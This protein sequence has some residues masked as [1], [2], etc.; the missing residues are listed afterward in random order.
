MAERSPGYDR[1]QPHRR[2]RAHRPSMMR[3]RW[4]RPQPGPTGCTTTADQLDAT[5]VPAGEA[6]PGPPRPPGHADHPTTRQRPRRTPP[7]PR[8]RPGW[9]RQGPTRASPTRRASAWKASSTLSVAAWPLGRCGDGCRLLAGAR[10]SR[11]TRSWRDSASWTRW[12]ATSRPTTA[13][14]RSSCTA[15]RCRTPGPTGASTWRARWAALSCPQF[16]APVRRLPTAGIATGVGPPGPQAAPAPNSGRW[17]G[18]DVRSSVPA[19]S[20][21]LGVGGC[22]AACS[23][24]AAGARGAPGGRAA[25]SPR[26]GAGVRAPRPYGGDHGGFPT[27]SGAPRRRRGAARRGG[28]GSGVE[29]G[30]LGLRRSGRRPPTGDD[31]RGDARTPAGCLPSDRHVGDADPCLSVSGSLWVLRV[32]R[33]TGWSAPSTEALAVWLDEHDDD[34]PHRP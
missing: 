8:R 34:W 17:D 24:L 13:T 28:R 11:P 19:K 29:A 15:T 22:P 20:P 26:S 18:N 31:V 32:V 12:S 5:I 3:W 7:S 33:V 9:R 16:V 6:G 1:R 23:H 4:R 25:P 21:G 10:A 30:P 2:T 14:A 27:V